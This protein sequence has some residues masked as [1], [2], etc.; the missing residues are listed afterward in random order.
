M[1]LKRLLSRTA[2]NR[3][4]VPEGEGE[5][6]PDPSTR[7][8][9]GG[10]SVARLGLVSIIVS[11]AVLGAVAALS[12][13]QLQTVADDLGGQLRSE[14]A[15]Q[16]AERLAGRFDAMGETV[17]ALAGDPAVVAAAR[18][19]DAAS[20]AA[21][22]A[23]A[24]QVFPGALR[25]VL[26]RP[27]DQDPDGTLRP[28]LGYACLDLARVAESGTERLPVEVH[29]FGTDDQHI[30]L[31]APVKVDGVHRATLLVSLDVAR[32]TGWL[33][34]AVG[35]GA[36]GELRQKGAGAVLVGSAG[37]A[38]LKQSG[39]AAV[40]AVGGSSLELSFWVGGDAPVS[41]ARR[42]A[43]L[44]PFAAGGI[45]L[46]V[47]GAAIVFTTRRLLGADLLKLVNHF[48]EVFANQR[49]Y[50]LTLRLA[51]TQ[52][53][54]RMLDEALPSQPREQRRFESRPVPEKPSNYTVQEG[55]SLE[56][57]LFLDKD[58]VKVEEYDEKKE[59]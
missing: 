59:R 38:G 42:I 2:R 34:S 18:S 41:E 4:H 3:E 17:A 24:A 43:F 1:N 36:Y 8:S 49:S 9:G 7:I 30:D 51:D 32:L 53:A 46:V 20:R 45:A 55:A 25:A 26:V 58:A 27:T 52:S 21:V 37:N 14:K 5:E 6:S 28:A 23:R 56:D 15:R 13:L 12:L 50:S 31:A 33:K 47:L 57:V 22:Q 11:V 48:V 19:A 29:L 35:Q 44:T 16:A 10:L 54:I 40:R 39:D